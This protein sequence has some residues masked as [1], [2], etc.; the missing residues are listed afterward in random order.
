MFRLK[1]CPICKRELPFTLEYFARKI[2][3]TDILNSQC[4]ECKNIEKRKYRKSETNLEKGREYQKAYFLK[5]KDK[6]LLRYK[7]Q[8]HKRKNTEQYKENK[9]A[10]DQRRRAVKN[11]TYADYSIKEWEECKEHFNH[12]CA[13]CGGKTELSQDHFIPL[14]KGGELTINNAIPSCK[15]CNS[16]KRD[17]DF[18]EWYKAQPFYSKTRERKILRYLNYDPQNHEQQLKLGC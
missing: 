15:K 5:N 9:K 17:R 8:Y 10:R 16:S 2:K 6:E 1:I 11:G 18:F 13:Y 12:Q 3:G 7:E 14:S 4:R